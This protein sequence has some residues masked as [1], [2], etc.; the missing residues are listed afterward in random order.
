VSKESKGRRLF[1]QN[2]ALQIKTSRTQFVGPIPPPEILIKYND[3]VPDAAERILKMAETQLAHRIS[4]E[5][6]VVS[7]N[8]KAQQRG[9]IYGL[10]VCFAAI[11]GGIYLVHTGKDAAG[12]ASLITPLAGIVAVFVYGKIQQKRELDDKASA[13]VAPPAPKSN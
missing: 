9:P 10:L 11:G 7:S 12:L 6:Q 1:N 4:I 5:N 8:C 13:L 2:Q 3:A